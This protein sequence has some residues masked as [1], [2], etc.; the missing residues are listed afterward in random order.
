MGIPGRRS[1]R[2]TERGFLIVVFAHKT[3]K[4]NRAFS[5]VGPSDIMIVPEDCL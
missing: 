5:V 3:T 2:S 4:Q 1:L